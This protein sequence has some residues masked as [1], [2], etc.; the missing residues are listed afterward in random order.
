MAWPV[1]REMAWPEALQGMRPHLEQAIRRQA[2]D[3][4][5]RAYSVVTV[6]HASQALGLDEADAV[7]GTS[8]PSPTCLRTRW[9]ASKQESLRIWSTRRMV[10]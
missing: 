8:T 4:I 1:M 10:L 2:S 5:A 3:F 7:S 9:P 6:A